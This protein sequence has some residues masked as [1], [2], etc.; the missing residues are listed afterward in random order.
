[1]KRVFA[2]AAVC[3][4]VA[5]APAQVFAGKVGNVDNTINTKKITQTN[6]GGRHNT[7]ELMIGTVKSSGFSGGAGNIKQVINT[8]EI[9]QT[10]RGGRHN[11]NK[12]EIGGTK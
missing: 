8:D 7:N 2:I 5:L 12:I 1:M 9:T 11:T 3:G 4:F 10:N 6:R